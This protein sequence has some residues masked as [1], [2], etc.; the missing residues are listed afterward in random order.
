MKKEEESIPFDYEEEPRDNPSH[1]ILTPSEAIEL[2]VC[3]CVKIGARLLYKTGKRFDS[4]LQAHDEINAGEVIAE[5]SSTVF[6]LS[7]NQRHSVPAKRALA[8]PDHMFELDS[9]KQQYFKTILNGVKA[10]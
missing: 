4:I 5:T 10:L 3:S 1:I 7:T 8:I 6:I 2:T 9:Q